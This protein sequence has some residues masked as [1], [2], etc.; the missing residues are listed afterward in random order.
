MNERGIVVNKTWR[1][2]LQRMLVFA[3]FCVV[4]VFVSTKFPS[5]VVHGQLFRIA[6]KSVHLSL[7][8]FW[9]LPVASLFD[10]LYRVYNVR[11]LI[12]TKFIEARTGVLSLRQNIVRVR[13]EDVRG[14]ETDQSIMGR[15]LDFGDVQIGTAASSGMEIIMTGV[16]APKEIQEMIQRE[17]DRRV[18]L[19]KRESRKSI[20]ESAINA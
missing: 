12:D 11:Y 5:T 10:L 9:L 13:Y 14:I 16:G 1:S 7:P 2:E 19:G 15:M 17:R 4:S 20:N 8:L 6:G 3:V 18:E